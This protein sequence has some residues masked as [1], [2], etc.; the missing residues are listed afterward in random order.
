MNLGF[1][2]LVNSALVVYIVVG[3]SLCFFKG[4][5]DLWIEMGVGDGEP[6]DGDPCDGNGVFL[7]VHREVKDQG[8]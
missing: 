4:C 7:L 6:L 5:C 1:V 2:C 3:G 8:I